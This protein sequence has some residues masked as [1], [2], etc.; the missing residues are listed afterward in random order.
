MEVDA[1]NTL[2]FTNLQL[3]GMDV[4]DMEGKYHITFS[5]DMFNLPNKAGSEAVLHFLFDRLNPT[6][7]KEQFRDCW[8][9]V[10]RKAEMQFRKVCNT[11]LSSIQADNPDAHLPRI[12]AS[13][14]LSPGGRKYI[15]LLYKFS[16]YVLTQAM[17]KEH[18]F[19]MD[20]ALV[21][22]A[23]NRSSVAEVMRISLEEST[24]Q[25][26]SSCFEQLHLTVAAN[27][28]WRESADELVKTYRRLSRAKRDCEDKKRQLVNTLTE[29]AKKQGLSLPAKRTISMFDS[30]QDIYSKHRRKRM[31]KARAEWS[32]LHSFDE[33][34]RDKRNILK[35]VLDS[36]SEKPALNGN[37]LGVQ[38]PNLLLQEFQREI[39]MQEIDNVYKGGCLNLETVTLLWNMCL[40]RYKDQMKSET[41]P[42]LTNEIP[43]I[44]AQV[45][46]YHS[47]LQIVQKTRDEMM[48]VIIPKIQAEMEALHQK[49]QSQP[50]FRG[51]DKSNNSPGLRLVA[52]T[53]PH[54]AFP[55]R[56][57]EASHMAKTPVIIPSMNNDTPDA[58][59]S[60]LNKIEQSIHQNSEQIRTVRKDFPHAFQLEAL[61]K[62]TKAAFKGSVL[63]DKRGRKTVYRDTK[64]AKHDKQHVELVGSPVTSNSSAKKK[65]KSPEN[66]PANTIKHT[67]RKESAEDALVDSIVDS[68]IEGEANQKDSWSLDLKSISSMINAGSPQDQDQAA[69]VSKDL[70]HRSPFQVPSTTSYQQERGSP[71]L[72]QNST[73]YPY[74]GNSGL[75]SSGNSFLWEQA[76][77]ASSTIGKTVEQTLDLFSPVAS[78]SAVSQVDSMA[79]ASNLSAHNWSASV[80][81]SPM[82]SPL[83]SAR[84]TK[85]P[86]QTLLEISDSML[87]EGTKSKHFESELKRDNCN[88]D[89]SNSLYQSLMRLPGDGQ[90]HQ[91]PEASHSSEND[92]DAAIGSLS[93]DSLFD[94]LPIDSQVSLPLKLPDCSPKSNLKEP[95]QDVLLG[96]GCEES[97]QDVLV[98]PFPRPENLEGPL[99]NMDDKAVSFEAGAE[100]NES[101]LKLSSNLHI[102]SEEILDLESGDDMLQC[103]E[104]DESFSPAKCGIVLER[105]K[106]PFGSTLEA[107]RNIKSPVSG[108][109]SS[110]SFTIDSMTPSRVPK[111]SEASNSRDH[112]V[113]KSSDLSENGLQDSASRSDKSDILS[114]IALLQQSFASKVNL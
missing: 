110:E 61:K 92:E 101:G 88:Q 60:V 1:M 33:D 94:S 78:T 58:V 95:L 107:K 85:L 62:N 87:K 93:K 53:P 106:S 89:V 76:S 45:D 82:N 103:L 68:M 9:V 72:H 38:I 91:D 22:P 44:K 100:E 70:I 42:D 47:N 7:F 102:S 14:L 83:S 112:L 114:Q 69:F 49:L 48:N 84:K 65:I 27:R 28:K 108:L 98:S 59:S 20:E 54:L 57:S 63:P 23:L 99:F 113:N 16:T 30:G 67:K 24:L 79:S 29:N 2:L 3:L 41:M 109:F 80:G 97:V 37:D 51:Y 111:N 6:L 13:L 18:G 15:H 73:S 105:G 19:D 64:S 75:K 66:A 52:P 25:L 104:L 10:D 26:H 90:P 43:S 39:Q 71:S 35:S 55:S 4:V 86:S 40:R 56:S 11:W 34:M 96:E 74:H 17:I 5:K 32:E 81:L 50:T 12:N 31:E 21:Y 46:Q 8:P 77:P 36:A